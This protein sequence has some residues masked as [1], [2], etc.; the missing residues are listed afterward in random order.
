MEESTHFVAPQ[1]KIPKKTGRKPL[2]PDK[3]RVR[4]GCRITPATKEYLIQM[5]GRSIGRAID[6]VVKQLQ[7]LVGAHW[8]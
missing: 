4:I 5:P 6:N 3:K 1:Q 7:E 2:G 8:A